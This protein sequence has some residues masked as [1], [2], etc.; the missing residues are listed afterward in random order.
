MKVL[1]CN[2]FY[3]R[4]GGPETVVQDSTRLLEA[5]GH[6]VIPFST[7]HPDNWPSKWSEYFV[8]GVDYH[9]KS[10]PLNMATE[11]VNIIYS[12]DAKRRMRSL[13]DSVKPDLVH[14]HNIYHQLSPSIFGPIKQMGIP[15]ALTLHDYK[16][17]CPNML[18]Y[19]DGEICERCRGGRFH[20]AVKHKCVF[21]ST[22]KS[23]VCATEMYLH[24]LLRIYEKNV[25]VFISPSQFL[26]DAIT[27]CGAGGKKMV[28]IPNIADTETYQ[29]TY[30]NDGY[31]LYFGKLTREKGVET[32]IRAIAKVKSA[33]LVVAGTG[34]QADELR[35]LAD[36]I[37]PGQVTFAGFLTGDNL[38]N[39]IQRCAFFTMPSEWYENC[40]CTILEAYSA[41]KPVVASRIGGIPELIDDGVD[42]FLFEP[43]N[44]DDLADKISLLLNAP[45]M[46]ADMGRL[47]RKRM[48]EHYSKVSFYSRLKSVYR[49]LVPGWPEG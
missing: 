1:I 2:K 32:L 22:A 14:A 37:A 41:G 3:R 25:D 31:I 21:G 18:F 42:G 20:N 10:G 4:F 38:R 12:K 28:H 45:T 9:A 15:I 19:V 35:A 6:E 46:P 40:P 8:P 36:D 7:S 33:K 30:D 16:L 24:R 27:R 5:D 13:L 26:I 23:M 43:T 29:A 39:A 44:S 17:A 11:A 49:E 34:S 48:E 47:G